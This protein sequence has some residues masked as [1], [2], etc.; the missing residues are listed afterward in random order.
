MI[1]I[2]TSAL[3]DLLKGDPDIVSLLGK[4][5]ESPASTQ[6]SYFELMLGINPEDPR[7]FK[8]ERYIDEIFQNM[9]KLQ[10]DD[11]SCKQASKIFWSLKKKG[12]E[13]ES[14]DC[15]IAGIFMANGITKIIT[16]NKKHFANI[17]G[18]TVIS[19]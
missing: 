3:I 6:I 14:S 10:I 19:Y 9:L 16:R 1:G 13:I 17:P 18:I 5:R 2:D 7:H 4:I 11:T 15:L 12:K 8:E